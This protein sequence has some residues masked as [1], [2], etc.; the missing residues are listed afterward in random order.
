[1]RSHDFAM[2][3]A[4]GGIGAGKGIFIQIRDYP[5]QKAI[6]EEA[7]WLPEWKTIVLSSPGR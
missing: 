7:R 6:T 3:T 2:A 5:A 4:E 1:M